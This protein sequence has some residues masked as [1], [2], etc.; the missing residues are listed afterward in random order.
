MILDF[1]PAAL[2]ELEQ[3]AEWYDAQGS[4]LRREF[5]AEVLAGLD[6]IIERPRAW[7]PLGRGLR[8]FRLSRF[9]YGIAYEVNDERILIIAIAHLHR[10][11]GYWKRRLTKGG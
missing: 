11:P 2:A 4:K 1:D 3:A 8:R 9:P 6:R 10:K 7:Q 5:L